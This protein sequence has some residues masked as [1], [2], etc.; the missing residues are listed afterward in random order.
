MAVIGNTLSEIGDIIYIYTQGAV[1]GNVQINSFTDTLVGETPTRFFD[2][3]FRY[4]LDGVNYSSWD[5]LTNAN[6]ANVTGTVTSLLFF[7]F[8]YERVGTDNTGLLEF[9]GITLNGN[10]IIQVTPGV[11]TLQSIFEELAQNDAL[12][13]A[14]CNNLLKKIYQAGI[15]PRFIERGEGVNDTDFV[16]FWS[17]I[18]CF[19]AMVSAFG[20][21]FDSILYKRKYL[22]E[23]LTQQG[24]F[25]CPEEILFSEL[26]FLANNFHD[27]IRKRGTQLTYKKLG[28]EL[29]DGSVTEIDG[30]WLRLICRNR[31]DEFLVDVVEKK[32]HGFCVDESSPLYNGNY[33]SKQINKTE[34]NTSDFVDLLL[35][36]LQ[37]PADVSIATDTI[38]DTARLQAN[39]STR[40]GFGFDILSPPP[41]VNTDQLIIVDKEIDYE[42]TFMVKRTAG[43][44][45]TL[46]FGVH[47]YNR[48]GSLKPLAFQSIAT[49]AVE[50]IFFQ[51]T[52]NAVTN[53]EDTWYQV[54]GIIYAAN[55]SLIA[56]PKYQKTNVI[57]VN[58]R[59]DYMEDIDMVKP[60]IQ[61]E[62]ATTDDVFQI[63]DFKMRPLIKG[64]NLL[65]LT[66]TG[67]IGVRNPQ[68][69]QGDV[70]VMNWLK[71]NNDRFNDEQVRNRIQDYLLPYQQKL[72]PIFMEPK[73]SD[74][75]LL[76]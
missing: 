54:R 47:G 11:T 68:F 64:K 67:E 46:W 76:L 30:E 60:F 31:Y 16:S 42:I 56:N 12:T 4:S 14:I 6:L 5:A 21:E 26:Q 9:G 52:T 48:N 43:T 1:A 45:G 22:K 58:L 71:N 55:S 18:C 40:V 50:N 2:K 66:T 37:T 51:D 69:I 62:G 49:G 57:G 53:K 39:G 59:M 20:D 24:L 28:T 65:P 19:L 61:I 8:R 27:E 41:L 36:D 72:V 15:L 38:G 29:L 32:K 63:H 3:Q 73:V 13:S 35:Y 34:E 75:Q 23:Y 33:K 74:K 70:I 25:Y 10:I 7:E 44:V 17:A